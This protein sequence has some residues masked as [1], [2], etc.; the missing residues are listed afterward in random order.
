MQLQQSHARLERL[1]N[2]ACIQEYGKD[3]VSNRKNILAITSEV[4]LDTDTVLGSLDSGITNM[5]SYW[6]LCSAE[7][8]LPGR[9]DLTELAASSYSWNITDYHF[10]IKYCLSERAQE[11]CRLQFSLRMMVVVI[12]C[13]IV[14]VV[15][16]SLTL[17]K[18]KT[19]PLVT[20]GDAVASF[21][22]K[23]DPMTLGM[24]L[25]SKQDFSSRSGWA[26]VSLPTHQHAPRLWE[27]IRLRWF[28]AASIKRW[29]STLGM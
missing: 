9:C 19:D 7:S 17:W 18:R 29:I 26:Q 21:L 20:V 14:K 11:R 22:E 13:N 2:K 15:C 4:T 27:P 12:I 24:C 23:P 8:P 16:M 6:W 10:P 28:R 5:E 25:S 1:E 3:I